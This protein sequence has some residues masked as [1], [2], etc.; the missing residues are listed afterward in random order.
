MGVSVEQGPSRMLAC[1]PAVN[2]LRSEPAPSCAEGVGE[3][4]R[5]ALGARIASIPPCPPP[6]S[7]ANLARLSPVTGE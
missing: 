2:P 1:H 4:M 3:R 5:R 6:R 7:G